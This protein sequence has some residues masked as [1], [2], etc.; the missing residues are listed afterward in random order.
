MYII[1]DLKKTFGNGDAANHV[2]KGLNFTVGDNDIVAV[3]GASGSGKTTL[4]N[5]LSTLENDYS[6]KVTYNEM[7]LSKLSSKQCRKLRLKEFGFIFQAFH[8]ISTLT[9]H[10][11][12]I[13][14][15][16][17]KSKNY[18]KSFYEDLVL[19]CGI[20]EKLMYYPHQLSGGEQQRVA[21]A[22]ALLPKPNVIFADEP[23]GNLDSANSKIVF[24]LLK[25]YAVD[26]KCSLVYVTH[27]MKY[28][29][30]ADKHIVLKDGIIESGE[31]INETK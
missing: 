8:L 24:T 31:K 14:S 16:T 9:V 23:T 2:L 21:I 7:E 11:N 22:R 5:I 15:A 13:L 3:T 6:G 12:I 27:E 29:E 18:D 26:N 25:D 30:F 10:E 1:E 28:A 4:I 20:K 17:A 19:R